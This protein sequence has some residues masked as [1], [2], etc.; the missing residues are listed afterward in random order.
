METRKYRLIENIMQVDNEKIIDKLEEILK[1][2]KS[3]HTSIEPYIRPMRKKLDVDELIAEQGFEG[4]DKDKIDRLIK[5]INL[6]TPLEELLE[7]I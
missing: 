3:D 5:D 2:Y 4:V 7:M 1:S 6:E